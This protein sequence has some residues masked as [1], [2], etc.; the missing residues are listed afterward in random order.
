MDVKVFRTVDLPVADRF[1]VWQQLMGQTH[2][3]VNLTSEFADDFRATLR[4]FNL[5]EAMLWPATYPHVTWHRPPRLVR[6][7][8]PESCHLT[9]VL[10]GEGVAQW[11]RAETALGPSDFHTNHT[12]VPY[13]IHCLPGQHEM[14]GVEVPRTSLGLPWSRM[15]QVVGQALSGRDGVGALLAQFLTQAARDTSSYAPAEAF[16]LGQVLTDLVT[17]LFARALDAEKLLPPETRTR[18]LALEV[19]AFIRRNLWDADLTPSSVAAAHFISLS[20]LHRLFQAEGVTVAAY[21]RT[22]RLEAARRELAGTS[23]ADVTIHTIAARYGF[24]DHTTFTRSF[25]AAYGTT[26][27][28]YRHSAH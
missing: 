14:I 8:D 27:R 28:D 10:R 13:V 18:N 1:D 11:D 6:Q 7:S 19:K 3:P 4:Q 21:I 26:P 16:R 25:R 15:Q 17:A 22:E 12:S 9:L 23:T 5:G 2:A 24:K 20:H